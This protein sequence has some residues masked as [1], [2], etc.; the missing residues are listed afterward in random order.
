MSCTPRAVFPSGCT[1]KLADS[2]QSLAHLCVMKLLPAETSLL[3]CSSCRIGHSGHI[4]DLFVWFFFSL[5]LNSIHIIHPPSSQSELLA[6]WSNIIQN[7]FYSRPFWQNVLSLQGLLHHSLVFFSSSRASTLAVFPHTN[8]W[9]GRSRRISNVFS[10]PLPSAGGMKGERCDWMDV[11]NASL[12]E[13]R[14][15]SSD[16]EAHSVLAQVLGGGR[17]HPPLRY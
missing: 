10:E 2:H 11:E 7:W 4:F 15:C 8:I 9:K 12:H 6:A 5:F 1:W 17:C 14:W 3:S 16:Y 13:H